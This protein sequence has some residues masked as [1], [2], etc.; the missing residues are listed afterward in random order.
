MRVAVPS[1]QPG[2]FLATVEKSFSSAPVYTIFDINGEKKSVFVITNPTPGETLP[3]FL[4]AYG[5]QHVLLTDLSPADVE[6]GVVENAWQ[7]MMAVWVGA[8]GKV[9][10]AIRDF[11]N[12]RLVE[13]THIHGDEKMKE[14]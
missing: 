6:L 11:I 3:S 12:Q 1:K 5:V 9:E 13:V 2:G 14:K 4:M 8:S 10:D 7:S